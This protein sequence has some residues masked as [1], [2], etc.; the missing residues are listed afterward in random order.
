MAAVDK[1][2]ELLQAIKRNLADLDALAAQ[3]DD[4]EERGVYKFYSQSFKVYE[5]QM[6]VDRAQVL[7]ERIAPTGTALNDWFL[8][9]CQT[10]LRHRFIWPPKNWDWE[11]MNRNWQAETQPI[12]EAFWHCRYFLRMLAR[13]GRELDEAPMPVAWTAEGFSG[14]PAPA[15]WLA[16]LYL[17]GLGW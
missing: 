4:L 1:E 11:R 6:I 14:S 13:F 3:L 5:L 10:A 7:F 8:S 16:V 2:R 12:L 17:Y 15:G 9:I